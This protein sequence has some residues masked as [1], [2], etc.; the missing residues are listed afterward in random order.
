MGVYNNTSGGNVV[1]T[2][3]TYSNFS[4]TSPGTNSNYV[5]RIQ[6]VGAASPG[7]GGFV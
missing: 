3:D 5:I 1:H 2:R 4:I 6:T 7:V